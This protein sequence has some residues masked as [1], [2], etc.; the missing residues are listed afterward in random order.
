ML[1]QKVYICGII[2]IEEPFEM[3]ERFKLYLQVV[4]TYVI[5]IYILYF[6]KLVIIQMHLSFKLHQRF[7]YC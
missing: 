7:F 2:N 3:N 6:T 5:Y 1:L 4:V